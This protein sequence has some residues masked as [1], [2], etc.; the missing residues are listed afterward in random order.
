MRVAL[1]SR[2]AHPLHKPGGLER[3]VYLLARHLQEQGVETVLLTRPATREGSFPGE[4]IHVPYSLVPAGRHGRVLDRTVNYPAF[5]ERLGQ[6]TADLVRAG[7]V[8]IVHAQGLTA[9]G[10]GRQR[11]KDPSL[12]A[13]LIMNPQGMEEHKSMGLKRLALSRLRALSREA[14]RLSDRVIATDEAT[15][16]EVPQ[17]LGVDASR[18][19]VVPNG[20]DAERAGRLTSSEAA[21]LARQA[22][23]VLGGCELVFL[24]VG[25]LER[26]KGF[27]DTLQAFQ[28]LA[29]RGLLPERWVWVVVGEGPYRKTLLRRRRHTLAS[30]LILAGR[31]TEKILDALYARADVFV[32]ATRFEGSSL[33]TL[34]AMAHG[35]PVVAT[36]AGGIPDKVLDD[37][38]GRLVPPG[39]VDALALA[40][41]DLA[42][43]GPRRIEMGARGRRLVAERFGW[44]MLAER[45]IALYRALLDGK[46]R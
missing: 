41:A 25:R 46:D 16:N 36:G 39:D 38:T 9:V 44:P 7:R 12:R 40:L 18:V 22:L 33:V 29:A 3:A 42:A 8:D 34:E 6:A 1:L 24:S 26:Y 11:L 28:R 17:L 45:T 13:P 35:L 5:A 43:S 19:V 2:A 15:R 23:P 37:E 20:I 27:G 10:Y 30:H 21:R 31:L 14:A 32:H 4:V